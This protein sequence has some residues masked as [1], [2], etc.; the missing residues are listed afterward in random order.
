MI[1]EQEITKVWH[2]HQFKSE[3]P[4]FIQKRRYCFCENHQQKDVLIL[5]INPVFGKGSQAVA[6]K[7]KMKDVVN[8]VVKHNLHQ[9]F[10]GRV[11]EML[12]NSDATNLLNQT[13]YTDLFYYRT[14]ARKRY[15]NQFLDHIDGII[16]LEDQLKI[17]Q[18]L[19]ENV[20]KPKVIIAGSWEV[21]LFLGLF[22][23]T[24][25]SCWLGYDLELIKYTKSGYRV[26]E[27][28]G[29]ANDA[30][31]SDEF[32]KNTN[33]IGTRVIC[34][35]DLSKDNPQPKERKLA[36]Q[37]IYEEANKVLLDKVTRIIKG[38]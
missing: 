37:E 14:K 20:I 25:Y 29:I 31:L 2:K 24:A 7:Y 10:F 38:K 11:Q 5:G 8:Y 30:A 9:H 13:A 12:Q 17:T 15:L 22:G 4:K 18:Q 26:Y 36:T 35:P 33:L 19:I 34:Y 28:K 32:V 6:S 23:T 27:I 1:L 3:L 16:F 21:M